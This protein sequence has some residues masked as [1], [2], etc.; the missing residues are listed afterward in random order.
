M[1]QTPLIDALALGGTAVCAISGALAAGSRKMDIFG[2]LVLGLATALGGGTLRDVILDRTP[3][4]W[5]KD[6]SYL[7]VALAAG[8]ITFFAGRHFVRQMTLLLYCDALGLALF[9]AIGLSCSLEVFGSQLV[10]AGMGMMTGVA[11]GILRDI[12][13]AQVPL[14]FCREIYA[15]ACL[16]GT[17]AYLA[18]LRAGLSEPVCL[19]VSVF[20]TLLLRAAAIRWNLSLPPL[21]TGEGHSSEPGDQ[22]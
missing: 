7:V 5:V 2:V 12:L 4:F 9:T 21:F 8:I 17:L 6:P 1:F 13:S 3:V 10:A 20:A 14:I 15:T 16:L 22:R 19:T 11:G 18:C